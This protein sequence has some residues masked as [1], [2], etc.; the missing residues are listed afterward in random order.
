MI[1]PTAVTIRMMKHDDTCYRHHPAQLL[2]QTDE[3]V[4]LFSPIG[5]EVWD[6][7]RTWQGTVDI[8]HIC[9]FDRWYNVLE[10]F[11]SAGELVELYAH[12]ASPATVTGTVVSFIDYELDVV[13]RATNPG[14]PQL[15]DEDE[16]AEAAQI[17]GYSAALRRKCYEAAAKAANLLARWQVGLPPI[18]ALRQE[19][20]RTIS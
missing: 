9:W 10:V 16:F 8:R 20:R 3:G 11:N 18:E 4:V 2:A 13:K 7:R 12:I 6:H 17:H 14:P 5:T 19:V 1:T 15:V